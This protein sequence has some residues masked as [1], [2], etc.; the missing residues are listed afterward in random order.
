[1]KI[2][3]SWSHTFSEFMG[4]VEE[5]QSNCPFTS[6]PVINMIVTI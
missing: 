1:M 4:F 2:I 5:K 3:I 6:I